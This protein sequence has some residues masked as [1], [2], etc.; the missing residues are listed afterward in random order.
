MTQL[1][2]TKYI[3]DL[4]LKAIKKG[5]YHKLEKEIR[6]ECKRHLDRFNVDLMPNQLKIDF[7]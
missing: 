5:G 2:S 6:L 7:E 3:N 1:E 4:K